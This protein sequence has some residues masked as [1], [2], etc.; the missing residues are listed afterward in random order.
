MVYERLAAMALVENV[1]E[2]DLVGAIA[3]DSEPYELGPLAP[4]GESRA[5]LADRIRRLRNGGGTDFKDALAIAARNL[6]AAGPAVRHVI[7]LTDG[8]T[9][10]HTED[11]LAL[12]DDLVN[13]DITVTT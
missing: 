9:N 11:H 12:L 4:A 5:A 1:G 13:A 8:D 2:H 6:I 7:L 10:R 3:F